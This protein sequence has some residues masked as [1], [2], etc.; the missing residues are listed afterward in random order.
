M[1]SKLLHTATPHAALWVM[2]VLVFPSWVF[3]HGQ[4]KTSDEQ[5][6]DRVHNAVVFL[7][8]DTQ[9]AAVSGSGFVLDTS[10][11]VVTNFHVV[12]GM[13]EVIRGDPNNTEIVVAFEKGPNL[14]EPQVVAS[15]Q[16]RDLAI[17]RLP[18]KPAASVA[19]ADSS[20]L[21]LAEPVSSLGFPTALTNGFDLV[22][23]KGNVSAMRTFDHLPY[24][25]HTAS[26]APGSSGGPLFDT[27]GDVVGVNVAVAAHKDPSG[28]DSMEPGNA[29]YAIPSND[30][31]QLLTKAGE[32][33]PLRQFCAAS[34]KAEPGPTQEGAQDSPNLIFQSE[35]FCLKPGHKDEYTANLHAG[36]TFILV[37]QRLSG[38]GSLAFGIGSN[39]QDFAGTVDEDAKGR[40]WL[41]YPPPHTGTYKV[42]IGNARGHENACAQ[43]F[44]FAVDQDGN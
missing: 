11:L 30:V 25:Q 5:L 35:P 36:R 44:V 9:K 20:Q 22:F 10:G 16:A 34:H 29:N 23:T 31:R 2:A 19:L 39:E 1:K 21:H 43:L 41:Q 6:V 12:N 13:C 42:I 24:V 28:H 26:V 33:V 27:A 15:D 7:V 37:V 40:L 14:G 4:T 3:A 38:F 18:H 17:L 8:A 32:P